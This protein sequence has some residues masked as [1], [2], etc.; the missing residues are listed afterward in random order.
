MSAL[1]LRV[2]ELRVRI[3]QRGRQFDAVRGITLSVAPG[4]IA[5]LIGESG[6]GKSL[7]AA[8]ILG[9]LPANASYT[10]QIFFDDTELHTALLSGKIRLGRDIGFVPQEP[11]TALN[12]TLRVGHQLAMPLRFHEKLSNRDAMR[13]AAAMLERMQVTDPE[14]VLAAYP[15]E[16]SGGLRQRALLANAFLMN[17]RLIVAD[18]PTTA[19]DVTVQSEVLTLLKDNARKS[20]TA[21]LFITHN[22]GVVWHLCDTVYVMQAG[23]IVEHGRSREVLASP[24]NAYTQMLRASLPEQAGYRQRIGAA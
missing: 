17:P 10:G 2:E 8:A 6:S 16:L 15:F 18:E 9:L 22:M 7:T 5:G 3:G 23:T 11:M 12:P 4:E 13:R 1:L 24:Q 20:N 19:L 14:R 21:V